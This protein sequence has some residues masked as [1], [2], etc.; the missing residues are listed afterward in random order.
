MRLRSPPEH[1]S[2]PDDEFHLSRAA[3]PTRRAVIKSKTYSVLESAGLSK[4]IPVRS[5]QEASPGFN[6]ASEA[7][8]KQKTYLDANAIT[9]ELCVIRNAEFSSYVGSGDK[10]ILTCASGPEPESPKR[11]D[12]MRWM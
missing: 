1:P 2:D 4:R 6:D 12:T 10:V 7:W 3:P 8:G 11:P 9:A 5:I